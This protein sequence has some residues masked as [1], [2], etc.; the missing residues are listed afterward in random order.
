MFCK[1]CGKQLSDD[2]VF[3]DACGISTNRP[4]NWQTGTRQ[5]T[6]FSQ[7]Q[8]AYTPP[9]YGVPSIPKPKKRTGLIVT[10]CV[11]SVLAAAAIVIIC[12]KFI[13]PNEDPE[14]F[15]YVYKK[16]LGTASINTQQMQETS[17]VVTQTPIVTDTT[18][19]L[20][21]TF[22]PLSYKDVN[23]VGMYF[24]SVEEFESALVNM[25]WVY[26]EAQ[27]NPGA[28]PLNGGLVDIG[29]SDWS[30]LPAYYFYYDYS[31]E[32]LEFDVNFSSILNEYTGNYWT[33]AFA[34]TY[35]A[36]WEQGSQAE[37]DGLMYDVVRVFFIDSDGYLV[38]NLTLYNADTDSIIAISNYNLFLPYDMAGGYSDHSDMVWAS[39][40]EFEAALMDWIWTYG[41]TDEEEVDIYI[42]SWAYSD[43]TPTTQDTLTFYSDG[44]RGYVAADFNTQ[45]IIAAGDYTYEMRDELAYVKLGEHTYN[46]VIYEVDLTYRI[47]IYGCLVER[48][49]L[50]DKNTDTYYTTSNV[51]VYIPTSP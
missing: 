15:K 28:T 42:G 33:Q 48:V 12:L 8:Q 3:C 35:M 24:N 49:E 25:E 27:G 1:N 17:S 37:Y 30:I 5:D 41:W 13:S 31:F 10:V 32:Y 22:S 51:N 7:P 44:T 38:E 45:E 46:G 29:L 20:P 50:Y 4:I 18:I 6:I 11:L 2:S 21:Y 9:A 34:D 14:N 26:C 19:D 16:L 39:Q 43:I 47:D 40:Q 23:H 36:C